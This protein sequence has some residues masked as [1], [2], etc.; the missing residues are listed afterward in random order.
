[1]SWSALKSTVSGV[2]SHAIEFYGTLTADATDDEM[3]H[4]FFSSFSLLSLERRTIV[5][6]VSIVSQP[7][8]VL[9]HCQ[10]LLTMRHQSSSVPSA[11][12]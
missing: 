9:L 6:T 2:S 11:I 10:N 5:S 3:R 8:E 7:R 1:M 12:R 4:F